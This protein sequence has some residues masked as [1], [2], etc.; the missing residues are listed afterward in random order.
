MAASWPSL[1]SSAAT[2]SGVSCATRISAPGVKKASSPSQWSE[3][4]GVPQAAASKSRPDGQNPVSAIA[5]L[6]TFNVTRDEE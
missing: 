2:A 5:R 1:Q 4:M 6:V 3:R